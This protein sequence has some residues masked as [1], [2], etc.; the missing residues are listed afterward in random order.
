MPEPPA[1]RKQQ[2]RRRT[3]T[4]RREFPI[5][6]ALASA[7]GT[8]LCGGSATRATARVHKPFCQCLANQASFCQ[9]LA[10][11]ETRAANGFANAWQIPPVFAEHWQKG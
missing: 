2:F 5:C 11:W 8:L 3:G 7:G 9:T 10:K 1:G 4:G 6:Q